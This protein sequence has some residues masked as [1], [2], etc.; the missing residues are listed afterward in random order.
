MG[1]GVV[2]VV[3]TRCIGTEVDVGDV[4]TAVHFAAGA[5]GDSLVVAVEN[6]EARTHGD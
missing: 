2:V 4:A 6:A 5:D 1:Y 3:G